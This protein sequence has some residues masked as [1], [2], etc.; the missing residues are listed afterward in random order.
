MCGIE[1]D[2]AVSLMD[3]SAVQFAADVSFLRVFAATVIRD[4][5]KFQRKSYQLN[6]ADKHL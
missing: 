4:V 5:A 3:L 1:D 6:C 2:M